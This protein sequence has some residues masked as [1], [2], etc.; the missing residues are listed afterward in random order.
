MKLLFF[1]ATFFFLNT[2][3]YAKNKLINAISI[4]NGDYPAVVRIEPNGCTG[5]FID[6]NL[7]ITAGHCVCNKRRVNQHIEVET[8]YYKVKTLRVFVHTHYNCQ[9]PRVASNDIAILLFP[10][11]SSPAIRYVAKQKPKIGSNAILVG[12]GSSEDSN[13]GV[14]KRGMN[15]IDS[16]SYDYIYLKD[17][18]LDDSPP[19]PGFNTMPKNGD[20]GGPLFVNDELVGTVTG[21]NS[22]YIKYVNL[23]KPSNRQFLDLFLKL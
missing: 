13:Y 21:G 3:I 22:S 16:I 5:T 19:T 12:F 1:L 14:K 17:N 23:N 6:H 9:N 15:T 11:N 18:S 8:H 2:N 7:A 4:D 20:S 10:D